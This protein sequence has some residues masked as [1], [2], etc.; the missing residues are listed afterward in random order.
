MGMRSI[1]LVGAIVGLILVLGGCPTRSSP[2][3]TRTWFEAHAKTLVAARDMITTDHGLVTSIGAAQPSRLRSAAGSR[4]SCSSTLR[5]GAFPW[6]CT[7]GVSAKDLA[8]ADAFLGLPKGRLSDYERLISAKSA[9]VAGPCDPL[10]SVTFVLEDS[11]APPCT[12]LY[13][14]VWAPS[15]PIRS[16]SPA[17]ARTV[18]THYVSLGDGWYED[19]CI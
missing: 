5:S 8:D 4:G 15:A 18:A 11:D 6:E 3:P 16:A 12:G 14:I 17:C 19:A 7:G 13:N 10:G 2:D 9:R 1:A